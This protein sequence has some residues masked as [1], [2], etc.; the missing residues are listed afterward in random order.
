MDWVFDTSRFY[1]RSRRERRTFNSTSIPRAR[2]LRKLLLATVLAIIIWLL[3]A[4]GKEQTFPTFSNL[5]DDS[6]KD[7]KS[8]TEAFGLSLRQLN[9]GLP[10]SQRELNIVFLVHTLAGDHDTNLVALACDMAN[11]QVRTQ[12]YLLLLGPNHTNVQAYRNATGYTEAV[13]PFHILDARDSQRLGVLQNSYLYSHTLTVI[14][15]L[16]MVLSPKALI[17][18]PRGKPFWFLESLSRY[19][20]TISQIRLEED[21]IPNLTWMAHLDPTALSAWNKPTIDIVVQATSGASSLQRLL[22]SLSAA[23][24]FGL[25]IPRLF[26]EFHQNS[27]KS[28]RRLAQEFCWPHD[29][30]ILRR[31]V[32]GLNRNHLETWYP[33][34]LHNYALFLS[35]TNE[36]APIYLA[37]LRYMILLYRYSTQTEE[38][39]RSFVY[40]ISLSNVQDSL[41]SEFNTTTTLIGK[42]NSLLMPAR[43]PFNATLLFPGP[44]QDY[45]NHVQSSM[46]GDMQTP[47]TFD[48]D[49][50]VLFL[51][52]RSLVLLSARTFPR[53]ELLVKH[54][55]QSREVAAPDQPIIHETSQLIADQDWYQDIAI[56]TLDCGQETIPV[57]IAAACE[58]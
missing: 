22:K 16:V 54:D 28:T 35:D 38:A 8:H 34:S 52:Q 20:T 41:A 48:E 11:R 44:V 24:S 50:F 9:A 7:F 33:N 26:V 4:R 49:D 53:L 3:A 10:L 58:I 43:T 37:Y 21:Q 30:L 18:T 1:K 55:V 19:D 6:I 51:Q 47:S 36:V 42:R 2:L 23:P 29:R 45:H 17:Y 27:S 5:Q 25:A 15:D 14:K 32:V 12:V 56:S 39:C 31:K 57:S 40:G 46:L 13:C